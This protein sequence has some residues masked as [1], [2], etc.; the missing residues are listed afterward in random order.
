M[1]IDAGKTAEYVCKNLLVDYAVK[2]KELSPYGYHAGARVR[3]DVYGVKRRTR[4]I[5]IF[6]VKSC[7]SDFKTDKKWQKYLPYCTHFAFVAPRGVIKL[8]ELSK[9]VG[10]VEVWEHERTKNLM[11][12]YARNCRKL[13][14]RVQDKEYIELL[15]AISLRV[16]L[17]NPT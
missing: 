13:N 16:V 10:L 11:H 8:E 3:F 4:E 7:R 6:E 9:G 1:K 17:G 5:R 12:R 14:E 2:G 15:E